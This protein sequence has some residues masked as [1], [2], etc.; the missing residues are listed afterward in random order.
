MFTRLSN[1]SPAR[2][3]QGGFTRQPTTT[4]ATPLLGAMAGRPGF[5]GRTS[6]ASTS[7]ALSVAQRSMAALEGA[8]NATSSS[9]LLPGGCDI[10]NSATPCSGLPIAND[11]SAA[12]KQVVDLVSN[13]LRKLTGNDN[14]ASR[15]NPG[16]FDPR[17]RSPLTPPYGGGSGRSSGPVVA[18][19]SVG[20]DRGGRIGGGG[21]HPD[22]DLPKK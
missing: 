3:S 14:G 13:L 4:G 21:D 6:S 1:Q 11:I 20:L 22:C 8:R 9:S 17:D 7:Q 12:L 15:N 16:G 2:L 10:A 5:L 18:P 19:P